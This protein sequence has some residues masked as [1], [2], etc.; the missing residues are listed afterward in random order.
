MFNKKLNIYLYF[1]YKT[2]FVFQVVYILNI[3]FSESMVIFLLSLFM[4]IFN[5]S[6]LFL[7][8]VIICLGRCL[9]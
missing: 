6:S 1:N 2:V 3:F 5:T 7:C 9:W 4:V 8:Y